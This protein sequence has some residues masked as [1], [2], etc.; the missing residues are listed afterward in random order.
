MTLDKQQERGMGLLG[1][2]TQHSQKLRQKPDLPGVR[3]MLRVLELKAPWVSLHMMGRGSSCSG[4]LRARRIVPHRGRALTVCT[5]AEARQGQHDCCHR[6]SLRKHGRGVG[7]RIHHE[8]TMCMVVVG[9][10]SDHRRSPSC[11]ELP[12]AWSDVRS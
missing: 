11:G 3:D 9:G 8:P 6:R 5:R 2:K 4:C 1:L 12:F 7:A 10:Q